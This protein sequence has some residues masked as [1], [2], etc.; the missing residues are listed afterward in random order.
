MPHSEA[1]H[2]RIDHRLEITKE[3]A[4]GWRRGRRT[5]R[6]RKSTSILPKSST[7]SVSSSPT[8]SCR[9][10][11]S[12]HSLGLVSLLLQ[13]S[14]TTGL[15]LKLLCLPEQDVG[16]K[17]LPSRRQERKERLSR[18]RQKR[19]QNKQQRKKTKKHKKDKQT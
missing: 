2:R 3:R 12:V 4:F 7:R 1:R 14:L 6:R 5:K 18:N 11:T 15:G 9:A 16:R 8:G 10:T 17:R 19:K 13:E